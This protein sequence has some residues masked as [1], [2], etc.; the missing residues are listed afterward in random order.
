MPNPGLLIISIVFG[1]EGEFSI[2]PGVKFG[3]EIAWQDA[4]EEWGYGCRCSHTGN[5][6]RGTWLR[7]VPDL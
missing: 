4:E 6:R 1:G 7:G 2:R 5:A 3:L